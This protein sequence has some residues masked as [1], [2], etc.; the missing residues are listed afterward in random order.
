MKWPWPYLKYCPGGT[1]KINVNL[2][3]GYLGS[4]TSVEPG[5]S[6]TQSTN[7]TQS[8]VMFNLIF[9]NSSINE[10]VTEGLYHTGRSF[11]GIKFDSFGWL[12]VSYI[13]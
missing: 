12:E 10:N 2:E 7:A 5:T 9:Y 1:E 11:I 3:S 4:G 13:T 6:Q 8:P